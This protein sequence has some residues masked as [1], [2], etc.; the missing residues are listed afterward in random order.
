MKM[1]VGTLV[2]FAFLFVGIIAWSAYPWSIGESTAEFEVH[3]IDPEVMVD[4]EDRPS[5]VKVLTWNIGY[6]Y[7]QGSEGPGY[8]HRG[9]EYYEEKL[10]EFAQQIKDWN[11]D[12]ICL[13]EVDF[14][15][16]RSGD[17]NQAQYLAAKAGYPY[18]AEAVSWDANYIPFPYWPLKN[19]FGRVKSGGAIL[20]KYPLKNHSVTLLEKPQSQPWWY[21]LFYLH[22]Y[23]Q[24]VTIELDEKEYKIVNLHLEAFDK[25]DRLKQV[26]QLVDKVKREGIDFVAGDFN[27]LPASAT[28][29]S[30]FYNE[31]DYENDASYEGM[32]VS[33]L[34]EVVPDDIYAKDEKTY[35]TF[36]AWAPDRRLDYIFYKPGLKMMRAEVLSSA[37]SD[38]L[39][40][41]A[42]FQIGSP[43]FNPYSQ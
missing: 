30:K 33:K 34:S 19:N 40:L 15:S 43:K 3:H 37:L 10:K 18:V 9:K 17:L 14:E 27:M 42:T 1:I 16:S 32:Q 31:D 41:R 5:V 7:G 22:R 36:P 39:P 35:F 21:N 20:S 6:L 12:V 28:K 8:E 26:G 2:V 11:P 4:M 29:R 23:F 13:Q 38:H 24:T 25:I